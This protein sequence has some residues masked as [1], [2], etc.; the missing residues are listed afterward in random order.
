MRNAICW[1]TLSTVLCALPLGARAEDD[2]AK[3]IDKAIEAK[4]GEEKLAKFKAEEWKVDATINFMG[5]K[6]P[7]TATYYFQPPT[8][9]RFDMAMEFGGK[10][11][12]ISAGT[13][14]KQ[15]WHKAGDRV[16]VMP[17]KKAEEFERMVYGMALTS[18]LPLKDKEFTLS[19]VEGIKVD[20]KPTVGV[21]V[22]K[23]GKRDVTLYFDKD[24]H[25]LVKTQT[26]VWNE[27]TD[28]DVKQEIFLKSWKE[29]NGRKIF[30]KR[31]IKRDG[32]DFLEEDMKEQKSLEKLDPKLFP[33]P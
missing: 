21:K 23:K 9:L 28:N 25:L 6:V 32:K 33:K 19:V 5:G 3:I 24:S 12:T 29:K 26:I 14:G 8:Y 31:V 30:E 10:K 27:F 20:D 1:M 15:A 16:E 17:M 11:T 22:S 2:A 18:L 13:D 7:Y 4:G